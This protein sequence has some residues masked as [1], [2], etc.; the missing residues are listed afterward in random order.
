MTPTHSSAPDLSLLIPTAD[1]AARCDSTQQQ[2]N[3]L[4]DRAWQQRY[5]EEVLADKRVNSF[6][7]L[8]MFLYAM[9]GASLTLPISPTAA[10]HPS[11][12]YG[13]EALPVLIAFSGFYLSVL[14]LLSTRRALQRNASWQST[15][16]QLEAHSG[17]QLNQWIEQLN[18][19]SKNY[20]H[21]STRTALAYFICTTWVVLYNYFTFTTSGVFG[22]VISLFISTMV[23]VMLDIQLLKGSSAANLSTPLSHSDDE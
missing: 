16:H 11:L 12:A 19:G 2:V 18:Q 1:D 15:L 6:M 23:Y 20:S 3:R 5:Q 7:L 22:S 13:I 14:F 17:Q 8:F 4:I 10:A 21:S 9:L